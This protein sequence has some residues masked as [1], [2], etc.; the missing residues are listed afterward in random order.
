MGLFGSFIAKFS[1]DRAS[2]QDLETFK[3]LLIEADIGAGFADEIID[4]V[5][6]AN[7]SELPEL[8]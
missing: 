7:L 8:I 2:A 4:L 3:N 5:K 6:K 1:K